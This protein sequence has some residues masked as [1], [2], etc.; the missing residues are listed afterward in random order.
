MQECRPLWCDN[1]EV[2]LSDDEGNH[3]ID[4][5]VTDDTP[6]LCV[7]CYWER[8]LKSFPPDEINYDPR[9]DDEFT[10][11]MRENS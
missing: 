11:Q 7:P 2:L 1:C 10:N 5:V 8:F 3:I 4:F 6:E 9:T